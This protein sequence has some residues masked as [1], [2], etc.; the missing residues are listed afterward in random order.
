MIVLLD[1]AGR[2]SGQKFGRLEIGKNAPSNSSDGRYFEWVGANGTL[3][4]GTW[5]WEAGPMNLNF[6][7]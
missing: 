3:D 7:Q 4:G 5:F 1:V 6:S 2:K